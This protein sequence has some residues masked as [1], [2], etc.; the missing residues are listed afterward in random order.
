MAELGA[1]EAMADGLRGLGLGPLGPAL[2]PELLYTPP[3]KF[4][5]GEVRGYSGAPPG[6]N[7]QHDSTKHDRSALQARQTGQD[8][9]QEPEAL[10]GWLGS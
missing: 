9:P 5:P 10:L 6:L 4:F 8:S 1:L 7:T 2:Q 3:P